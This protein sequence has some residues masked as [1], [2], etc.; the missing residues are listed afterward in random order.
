M[1]RQTTLELL[2]KGRDQGA[3]GALEGVSGSLEEA[4]GSSQ[5][6][7]TALD[8]LGVSLTTA[9]VI[10]AGKAT[11]EFAKLGG[12][13]LRAKGRF[14]AFSGSAVEMEQN[15]QAMQKATIGAVKDQVLMQQGARMLQTGLAESGDEMAEMAQMAM[16][17]G[18]STESVA[19]RIE[20]FS[21]MMLNTSKPRLDSYGMSA[22]ATTARME[23]LQAAT[24]G[25]SREEAFKIAVMEQGREAMETL[26]DVVEDDLLAFEQ[27]ETHIANVRVEMAERLTPTLAEA[28]RAGELL[29]TWDERLSEASDEQAERVTQTSASYEEYVAGVLDAQV[30]SRQLA[31]TMRD[32]AQESLLNSEINAEVAANMGVLSEEAWRAQQALSTVQQSGIAAR[33]SLIAAGHGAQ[34]AAEPMSAMAVS[35]EEAAE[36]SG[37]LAMKLMDATDAQIANR[38]I[39]MLD[40]EKMGAEAYSTAIRD[41][42]VGF[43]VMDEESIA[44]AENM[45]DLASSIE[46]GIIPAE[47]AHEALQYLI[48]DAEDGK[49]EMEKFGMGVETTNTALNRLKNLDRPTKAF[50]DVGAA[51]KEETGNISGFSSGLA[52]TE[53]N[54]RKL[55]SGSP[56]SLE[57]IASSSGGDGGGGDDDD[58][59]NIPQEMSMTNMSAAS[60][61]N[62]NVTI[63]TGA[64]ADTLD[65]EDLAYRVSEVLAQ[66]MRSAVM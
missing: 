20:N 6:L 11:Y 51:A 5:G 17:L 62:V 59:G 38:L 1:T 2:L 46:E 60:P 43:D 47:E 45:T 18:D 58:A 34:Q 33:E 9:G 48:I 28:A 24:E 63:N 3:R 44:L 61:G 37:Q 50:E 65:I 52:A 12:E 22:S 15:L 53:E 25:L 19:E 27:L 36:S 29:L 21:L 57:V 41:I 8:A 39:G 16:Y 42:G 30:A 66:R 64:I 56:Y 7:G 31:S 32:S 10:A 4:E 14:E 55:V 26:G 40:P 23:E 54:L 49:V 13:S 35:A